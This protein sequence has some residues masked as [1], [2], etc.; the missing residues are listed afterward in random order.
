M[1]RRADHRRRSRSAVL[2]AVAIFVLAQFASGLLLDYRG[3][4]IRFPSAAAVTNALTP[5]R[6]APDIVCVG[7]S[8]FGC[9]IVPTEISRLLAPGVSSRRPPTIFNASTPGGDLITADFIL[10]L[11]FQRGVQPRLV[12]IEV[13]PETL[14]HYNEWF[15]YHVRR[16]LRWDDVPGHLKDVCISGQL[17]RLLA[18]RLIPLYVHR[19]AIC[20]ACWQEAEG[21]FSAQA[22][23]QAAPSAGPPDSAANPKIDWNAVLGRPANA[24]STDQRENTRLGLTQPLHWLRHYRVGGSSAAALEHLLKNCHERGVAVILVG[25]PV[26]E[27]HRAF[28][29]PSIDHLYLAYLGGLTAT[30]G[31]QYVECRDRVPDALFLDNHHL[32]SKGGIFFSRELAVKVLAPAWQALAS[33]DGSLH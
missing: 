33:T 12:V 27:E 32:S 26:T 31:C 29:T 17:V 4:A 22:T 13:S 14:N 23:G 28:Y 21:L 18:A 8:R 25:V 15:C 7:S 9:G 10:Q 5:D 24:P 6:P 3:L 16:Q 30:Y 2:W 11:L 19:H 20:K 1:A